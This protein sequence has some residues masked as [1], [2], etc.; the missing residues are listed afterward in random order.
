MGRKHLWSIYIIKY[1]NMIRLCLF[2][3]LFGYVTSH[4]LFATQGEKTGPVRD[5]RRSRA[6]VVTTCSTSPSTRLFPVALDAVSES[7]APLGEQGN[8]QTVFA[9]DIPKRDY[10]AMIE[11][12]RFRPGYLVKGEMCE[13][14]APMSISNSGM[15]P[16]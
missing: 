14:W 9:R 5:T 16:P 7:A 8:E 12:Y 6:G 4:F 1:N 13:P 3:L 15:T 10:Y 11:C 2:L